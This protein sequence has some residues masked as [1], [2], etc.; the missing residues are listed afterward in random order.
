MHSLNHAVLGRVIAD[1]RT[2]RHSFR[3]E[4][5][6][7]P[8]R[9]PTVPAARPRRLRGRAPGPPS[10][11][12]DGAP[13]GHLSRRIGGVAL[14]GPAGTLLRRAGLPRPPH[15]LRESPRRRAGGAARSADR[16][17]A[18]IPTI[19]IGEQ[20]PQLFTQERFHELGVRHVRFVASWDAFKSDWQR[21]ELDAY[22]QAARAANVKVLLGFGRSRDPKRDAQA[23]VGAGLRARVPEVPRALSR[24][25][26]SSSRGTRPTTA[27]SR[28]AATRSARR[29]STWPRAGTAAA[30]R[31][32]A[33]ACS[34]APTWPSGRRT[35]RRP[36]A[37]GGGSS[38]A[39]TTTSTPTSSARGARARC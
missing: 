7:R 17:R 29:S 35:S 26:T 36:R 37:R 16:R 5:P 23:A 4:F 38:G 14:R 39:C 25:S 20:H 1:E 13:R 32:S 3:A 30:A 24:T 2:G 19:G 18:A 11:Q 27:A 28:R 12:R 8:E 6:R 21:A 31:S 33:R 22:M 10:R 9:P 34:T 15:R